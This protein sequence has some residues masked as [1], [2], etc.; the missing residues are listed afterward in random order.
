MREC[1]GDPHAVRGLPGGIGEE[2]SGGNQ[3]G[4]VDG[5][6]FEGLP[7]LKVGGVFIDGNAGAG[8]QGLENVSGGCSPRDY[9]CPLLVEH[10]ASI[11]ERKEAEEDSGGFVE[12]G[13]ETNHVVPEQRVSVGNLKTIAAANSIVEVDVL[14]DGNADVGNLEL[15]NANCGFSSCNGRSSSLDVGKEHVVSDNEIKEMEDDAAQD[16]KVEIGVVKAMKEME[17]VNGSFVDAGK[18]SNNLDL[19]QGIS[20]ENPKAVESCSSLP[21]KPVGYVCCKR[22]LVDDKY[23][24]LLLSNIERIKCSARKEGILCSNNGNS[25]KHEPFNSQNDKGLGPSCI[26]GQKEGVCDVSEENSV[27]SCIARGLSGVSLD[28]VTSCFSVEV[29]S[30]LQSSASHTAARDHSSD[31]PL[32][33]D[34]E[35][36]VTDAFNSASTCC[37]NVKV[38]CGQVSDGAIGTSKSVPS[39]AL[40]RTNPKRAASLRSIQTDVRSDHLTRNRNNMRKHNKP[41]ELGTIFSNITDKKMEVRRKRSCFQRRTRKSVWGGT[42]SLITHFMEN[43]ELTVSSFHLAQ[44]QNTNSKISQN[45]RPRRKKQMGHG[46]RN[47]ISPKSEFA[48]LTQTMHLNDQIYLQPQMPNMVD[49]QHSIEANNDAV[50]NL[51]CPSD[52]G[53]SSKP[54]EADCE[55]LTDNLASSER[56]LRRDGQQGEKD[57]ES[58]LTQDASF[59]NMLGEC[60]GVSSHSGSETLMERTVDKHLVDPE[61]SPDSD[62][63]NPVVDVGVALIESGTFQDN[64]VNQSIIV[65]KLTVLNGMC[66]KLLT[67]CDAIVSPESA[68][69]LEVQLQTENKE[70]SKFCEASA[71][72][73][74]SSEEHDLIKEKLHDL[75]IQI[76][77]VEPL[78]YVRKKRNGFKA[79]SHLCS[80]AIK[81]AKGKE[82]RGKTYPDDT[83]NG[84]EEL[85]CS[86]GSRKADLGL[87]VWVSTK[88]DTVNVQPE[89]GGLLITDKAEAHKLSRSSKK[90]VGKA[91]LS[92]KGSTRSRRPKSR[93]KKNCTIQ[94]LGKSRKKENNQ[95]LDVDWEACASLKLSPGR[96]CKTALN[97]TSE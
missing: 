32:T 97:D 93:G 43:D 40:R 46:D 5:E 2:I 29:S 77:D 1:R 26:I 95:T 11:K 47:L 66:A 90:R 38:S 45:S 27:S 24:N 63:Y 84:V 39:F 37:S 14:V 30:F 69:S 94:K 54:G 75:D 89:D 7:A 85:G 18:Q 3:D 61:S 16:S 86:E 79:R 53:I 52:L 33:P 56:F 23:E 19:E 44:I 62:I 65:P 82:Y 20:V 80:D 60:P 73:Y 36:K 10:E 35:I 41:A 74:A 81:E 91:K 15:K 92:L 49:S 6:E 51:C 88:Q 34:C 9:S 22:N 28:E 83:T 57:M 71:K 21:G 55:P 87:G 42:S 25:G 48:F 64:G 72:A 8:G 12:P 59:D 50:P 78:K 58:T 4:V 17:E 13:K 96:V 67:S 70:E 68:S 76:T 31:L